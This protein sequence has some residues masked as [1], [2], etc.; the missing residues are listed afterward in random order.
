MRRKF[1][2]LIAV[3]LVCAIAPALQGQKLLEITV[4]ILDRLLRGYQVEQ[5]ETTK[6]E[7]QLQ[8]VDA[9]L[10]KFLECKRDFE[11]AGNAS[12]SSAGGFA[13]RIAMRAK[14]GATNEDGFVKDRAKILEGPDN[15][16]AKAGN[17]KLPDYRMFR[18]RV[19]GYLGGD[20]SG[21]SQASLDLLASRAGA[22]SSA[23]GISATPVVSAGA[24]VSHPIAGPGVWTT[25]YAWQYIG[26]LFA[27]QYL[28]GATLF[29]TTYQPGQ[30]TKWKITQ[31]DNT[32]ETQVLERAFLF[33]T[34]EGGEW[35]RLK[36][37]TTTKRDG[38]DE[39]E[40]VVLEA[41][42]KPMSDQIKQLVRMRG[43]LPGNDEPQELIVPQ[44]MTM[45][46]MSGA[47]PLK[48][49][50]ESVAGATIGT[51][52]VGSFSAKHVRYGSGNGTLDWWLSDAAPGGW[53]RF[54]MTDNEKKDLYRME[55][56][57]QGTGA[58]SETGIKTP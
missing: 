39:S 47:F 23:F 45:V 25:D 52:T 51:E 50:P 3:C 20:R 8:E 13:A 29:E 15:A 33:T 22:L 4:D 7:P 55:M 46:S 34:P 2:S 6:V 56:T 30:W 54:S 24:G 38:K 48:P 16:A 26:Q 37:T 27:V 9:K 41:L 58:Q 1:Q 42:F 18:D 11:A 19:R 10:K 40:T 31:A 35:W 36:T 14:C 17:F 28:S 43:K 53:V 21:L 12:G 44:A 5:S 57:G 32:D 49:T